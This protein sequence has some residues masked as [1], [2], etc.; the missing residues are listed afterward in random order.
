VPGQSL[1]GAPFQ[2][3]VQQQ[4]QKFGGAEPVGGGLC[5]TGIERVRHPAQFQLTQVWGAADGSTWQPPVLRKE[6]LRVT[7]KLEGLYGFDDGWFARQGVVIQTGVQNLFD[8]LILNIVKIDGPRTGAFQPFWADF[9]CRPQD[10]LGGAQPVERAGIE[11]SIDDV[12]G[13]GTDVFSIFPTFRWRSFQ[14]CRFFG[15]III[16]AGAPV[17][18]AETAQMA[19]HQF[20]TVVKI[21][22][23]FVDVRVEAPAKVTMRRGIIIAIQRDV[24]IAMNF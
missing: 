13:G 1:A 18:C 19:G 20:S 12:G 17:P 22:H 16:Q 23:L 3:I 9:F 21:N 24:T 2:F 10:V 15:R 4:R 5:G 8:P 11:Q 14:I 7:G 6:F